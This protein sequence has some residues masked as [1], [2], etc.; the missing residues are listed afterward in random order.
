[1]VLKKFTNRLEIE[2]Y[3]DTLTLS[4]L[5]SLVI[6]LIQEKQEAVVPK[7]IPITREQFDVH[8]RILGETGETRGRPRKEPKE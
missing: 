2:E 5:R 1:M 4:A 7:R 6:D 3:V 8:F